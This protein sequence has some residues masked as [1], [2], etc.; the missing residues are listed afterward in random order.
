MNNKKGFTLTEMIVVLVILAV[1][2]AFAIPTMLGYISSSQE[3]LCD[4]T[5]LDMVRLYKTSLIGKEASASQSGFENFATDN[6]GS[7]PQCPAGGDYTYSVSLGADGKIIAEIQCS[8]H[9]SAHVLTAE[10]AAFPRQGGMKGV[11]G[12]GPPVSYYS[13]A[14]TDII[15]P[16]VLDGITV[17][18]IW[19]EFFKNKGLT[20]VAFQ[21]DSQLTRIHA[22]AFQNNNLT[23]IKIPDS[24]VHIDVRAFYGNSI[25][26]IT[27][28]SGVVMEGDVF[29]DNNDFRNAYE[30]SGSG[31]GTYLFVD[32]RWKKQ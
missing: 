24:V 6:W 27:I 32:G 12:F 16:K 9:G 17:T 20:S 25:T 7:I 1:L 18:G 21:S 10:E 4:I 29:G 30:A 2:A 19:Q 22:R 13:G 31:A 11:L 15:I 23:E 3:K 26:K 8:V 5:R 14:A 28:G